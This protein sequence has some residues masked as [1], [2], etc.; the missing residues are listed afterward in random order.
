MRRTIPKVKCNLFLAQ[1]F[2]IP[3]KNNL[4]KYLSERSLIDI[5]RRNEN[6]FKNHLHPEFLT[7][8]HWDELQ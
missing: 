4:K 3:F 6:V 8:P 1:I 7:Y 2:R 5:L